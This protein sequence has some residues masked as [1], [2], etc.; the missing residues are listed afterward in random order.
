MAR[1][2]ASATPATRRKPRARSAPKTRRAAKPRRRQPAREETSGLVWIAGA[3]SIGLLVAA[4]VWLASIEKPHPAPRAKTAPAP[5]LP[6]SRP[7]RPH[8]DASTASGTPI[9]PPKVE[10][11]YDFY[12]LLPKQRVEVPDDQ[13]RGKDKRQPLLLPETRPRSASVPASGRFIL[14]AGSFRRA[15]DANRRRA[16]LAMMGV[17]S[18]IE[19]VRVNDG[20]WHRVKIGPFKSLDEANRLRT[21]LASEKIQTMLVNVGK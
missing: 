20:A 3:I 17:E 8:R 18:H 7:P 12:D 9:E 5:P 2:K 19:K 15:K 16:Q 21:R 10:H 13:Y 14:Q 11:K 6:A 1:R 4:V